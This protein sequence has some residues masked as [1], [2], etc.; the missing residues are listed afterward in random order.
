MDKKLEIGKL[1]TTPIDL[2]KLSDV[3]KEMLLLKR[4]NMKNWFKKLIILRPQMKLV[5][6]DRKK[7]NWYFSIDK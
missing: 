7:Q 3:I 2:S 5:K 1:E 6:L 4:L